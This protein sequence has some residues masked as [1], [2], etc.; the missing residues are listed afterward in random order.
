[1]LIKN[2]YLLF[3]AG[4]SGNYVNWAICRS[5]RDLA[6]GTV[7]APVTTRATIEFGGSGTSHGH[8]RL[9][10]HMAIH[11][12][13]PWLAYNR[14]KTPQTYVIFTVS[15]NLPLTID[16]LCRIDPDP[17]FIIIHDDNDLDTQIYGNL[18]AMLKWPTFFHMMQTLT[19]F[20][21]QHV[22]SK[23]ITHYDFFSAA[24]DR[25]IR[26]AIAKN[27]IPWFRHLSPMKDD[28]EQKCKWAIQRSKL[29][30]DTRHSLQPHELPKRMHLVR[31]D[32]PHD[33]I[34]QI[35]C[36]DIAGP[37][38]LDFMEEFMSRS[39]CSSQ[40][41]L[42]SVQ[43]YH[44]TYI[45]AQV[46]LQWFQSI[47]TWKHQESA[48]LTEFLT[49]NQVVEGFVIKEILHRVS[50]HSD[51]TSVLAGWETQDLRTINDRYISIQRSTWPQREV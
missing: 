12:L 34:F 17:V 27:K 43:A 5:D 9:P 36:R 49:S 6:D 10:T 46:N 4:Y 44:Q 51:V 2:V 31:D 32:L 42:N 48:E 37:A 14:P 23:D 38:F 41:C 24:T 30:F 15:E 21:Q 39:G 13:V 11:D 40:W 26:N 3:P 28:L 25:K 20:D 18:N 50:Y 16:Y 47:S 19:N 33:N 22:G 45:D 8:Q 35:S 7:P 1:M 29:W